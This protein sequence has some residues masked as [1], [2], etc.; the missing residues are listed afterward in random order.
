ME[1]LLQLLDDAGESGTHRLR[2]VVHLDI[3]DANLFFLIFAGVTEETA[4]QSIAESLCRQVGMSLCYHV[5][6]L[7]W[8]CG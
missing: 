4:Q 1:Q 8:G 3:A 7:L 2:L 5:A 6:M